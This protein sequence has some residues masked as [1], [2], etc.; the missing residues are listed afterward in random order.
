[1]CYIDDL[2]VLAH[3]TESDDTDRAEGVEEAKFVDRPSLEA[4]VVHQLLLTVTSMVTPP[5]CVGS[6]R[7]WY[8]QVQ[9]T[10]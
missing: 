10:C 8:R 1:V 6:F 5:L 9:A 2:A 3:P 7:S 4:V